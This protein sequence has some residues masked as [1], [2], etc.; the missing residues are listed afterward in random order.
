MGLHLDLL[1]NELNLANIKKIRL[2]KGTEIA[3]ELYK[4]KNSNLDSIK[5]NNKTY[6]ESEII[7]FTESDLINQAV[8]N[9]LENVLS[10]D[11]TK[12]LV[13]NKNYSYKNLNQ[14][15]NKILTYEFIKPEIYYKIINLAEISLES[16]DTDETLISEYISNIIKLTYKSSN[17]TVLNI[18]KIHDIFIKFEDIFFNSLL[19]KEV[20]LNNRNINDIISNTIWHKE[21]LSRSNFI[22]LNEIL[23]N[24]SEYSNEVYEILFNNKVVLDFE[25]ISLLSNESDLSITELVLLSNS[26]NK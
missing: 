4:Y 20:A 22:L 18:T 10:F 12:I 7:N 11:L 15:I 16:L 19:S 13:Y 24:K 6:I 2:F 26:L 9:Y 1:F 21:I 25:T 17:N 5:E 14:V 8:L 3:Y 23:S